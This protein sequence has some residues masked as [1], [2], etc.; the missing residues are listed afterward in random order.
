AGGAPI[1]S[2]LVPKVLAQLKEAD[3]SFDDF[4]WSSSGRALYFEGVSRSVR[5]LWKVDVEAQSLRWIAGPERLTTGAHLDTD[6]ALS[7]NGKRLAFTARTERTRLWS[8]PFD[9]AAGRVKGPGQPI[10]TAGMDACYPDLSPDGQRVVFRAQ[11]AGRQEFRVQSLKDGQE[12][13]LIAA[14]D[15]FRGL[16]RWSRDGLRMVYFR[17]RTTSP[18]GAQTE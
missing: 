12:T 1:K 16:P 4:Q 9:A 5:N 8:L 17:L 14:D 2:E 10:T 11:R 3:V 7:P 18:E 6:L 15:L 13:L